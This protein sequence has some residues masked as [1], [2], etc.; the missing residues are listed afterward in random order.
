MRTDSRA[1]GTPAAGVPAAAADCP[2]AVAAGAAG[3]PLEVGLVGLAQATARLTRS[4]VDTS[5][6]S[7]RRNERMLSSLRSGS[8][9]PVAR[10]TALGHRA[11]RT[12]D[13]KSVV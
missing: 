11:R 2:L 4:D 6:A 12:P 7:E 5:R 9:R 13:R 8:R 10:Q 1:G 3:A